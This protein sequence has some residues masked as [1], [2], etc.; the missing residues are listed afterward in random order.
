MPRH[1]ILVPLSHDQREAL[2][3]TFFLHHPAPP[4]R[5]TAMTPTSTPERRPARLLAFYDT[6]LVSHFRAEEEAL[7]PALRTRRALVA[8]LCDDHRRF[9][10]LRDAV[11]AARGDDA[12]HAALTAFADLLEAHVRR[13][14]RELF[15]FFPEGIGRSV[16]RFDSEDRNFGESHPPESNRR[17]TDYESVALPTELGWLVQ[18]ERLLSRG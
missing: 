13:E 10:E 12:I 7:F 1:P 4:G 9:A 8:S 2:G 14:E 17:P 11:A 6:Y 15:T 16:T 5:V 3:L 18:R